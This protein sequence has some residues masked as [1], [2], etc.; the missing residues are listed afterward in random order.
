[1]IDRNTEPLRCFF[2]IE[3]FHDASQSLTSSPCVAQWRRT[4]IRRTKSNEQVQN[5]SR[6]VE[7]SWWRVKKLAAG[8]FGAR[9]GHGIADAA[10]RRVASE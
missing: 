5:G 7:L 3:Q 8:G 9:E 10:R 1:M 4:Q 2:Q 6:K